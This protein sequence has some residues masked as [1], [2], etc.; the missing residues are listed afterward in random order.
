MRD[1]DD[2]L[3]DDVLPHWGLGCLAEALDPIPPR[4]DV[5]LRLMDT[6]ARE[7]KGGFAIRLSELFDL[8]REKIEAIVA[9][10]LTPGSWE[11]GPLPGVELL[12]FVGG[13]RV[14]AA[15]CGL[16]RFPPGK[17]FPPHVHFGTE[18]QF[19][20]EGSFTNSDGTIY[21]A[22]DTL[23]ME[24]GSRHHFDVGDHGV[25]IALVLFGGFQLEI[26]L[27]EP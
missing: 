20:I 12:H 22:G 21:R 3:P 5:K 27:D 23:V 7:A 4:P 16:V 25:T 8:G 15:D 26:G 19:V 13:P 18:T 6:I 17:H 2:V 1:P 14:A 9:D 10:A 11:G 24:S